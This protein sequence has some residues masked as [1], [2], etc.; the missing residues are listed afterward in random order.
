MFKSKD[1]NFGLVRKINIQRGELWILYVNFK[2]GISALF[3][4]DWFSTPL[5]CYFIVAAVN[6]IHFMPFYVEAK[7]RNTPNPAKTLQDKNSN[8]RGIN[9]VRT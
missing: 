2:N 7:L 4:T 3:R 5:A 1:L 6:F 8:L 9:K